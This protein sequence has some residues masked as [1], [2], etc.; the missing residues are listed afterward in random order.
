MTKPL[1]A[2]GVPPPTPVLFDFRLFYR[3]EVAA[4]IP[5]P[6]LPLATAVPENTDWTVIVQFPTKPPPEHRELL[7]AHQNLQACAY[8]L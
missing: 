8:P 1:V 2:E 6:T 4:G 3:R 7:P 5:L